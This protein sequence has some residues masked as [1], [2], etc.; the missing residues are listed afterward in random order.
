MA[1]YN[2]SNNSS[3]DPLTELGPGLTVLLLLILGL[4]ALP[5]AI[6]GLV[7]HRFTRALPW[8]VSLLLW[9]L[10]AFASSYA[11]YLFWVHGLNVLFTKECVAYASAYAHANFNPLKLPLAQLWPDTWPVWL[12]TLVGAPLMGFLQE[13]FSQ[14]L[15]HTD[16]TQ[17]YLARERRRQRANTRAA[18]RIRRSHHL[19]RL[20]TSILGITKKGPNMMVMGI[21]LDDEEQEEE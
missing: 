8:R 16:P 1:S 6:L 14:K 3:F 13:V 15:L 2:P 18:T 19:R 9:L 20:P 7:V 17:A 10:L 4:F 21:P 5:G 12:R 11:L